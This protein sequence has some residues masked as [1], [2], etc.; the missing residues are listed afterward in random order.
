MQVFRNGVQ[1][2]LLNGI[3]NFVGGDGN[4]VIQLAGLDQNN[5]TTEYLSM[6]S[7]AGGFDQVTGTPIFVGGGGTINYGMFH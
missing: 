2:G 1:I 6:Y 3:E 4:D 7:C 5:P